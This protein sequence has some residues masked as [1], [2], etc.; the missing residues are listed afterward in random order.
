LVSLYS[1]IALKKAKLNN[2]CGFGHI[3]FDDKGSVLPL[4]PGE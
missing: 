3:F 2:N 4:R 1:A